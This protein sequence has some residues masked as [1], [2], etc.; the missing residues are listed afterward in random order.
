[1]LFLVSFSI[2]SI[3]TQMLGIAHEFHIN[4]LPNYNNVS[5]PMSHD[6]QFDDFNHIIIKG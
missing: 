6:G 4:I 3:A 1:M 2:I 5:Q